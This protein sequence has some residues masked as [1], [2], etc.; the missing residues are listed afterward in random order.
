MDG[1]SF[2]LGNGIAD[3]LVVPDLAVTNQPLNISPTADVERL[4]P[5]LY[6]SCAVTRSQARRELSN[7]PSMNTES[8]NEWGLNDLFSEMESHDEKPFA[9]GVSIYGRKVEPKAPAE[10]HDMNNVPIT[11][12]ML[13]NAQQNDSKLVSFMSRAVDVEEI[14]NTP[15]CFYVKSG[16]LMPKFQPPEVPASKTWREAHQIVVPTCYKGNVL[17]LAHDHIGGHLGV[18]KTSDKILRYFYWPGIT[19]DVAEY[20]RSCHTC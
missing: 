2:L 9:S 17:Q 20:C 15:V 5:D 7:Q 4:Y 1:V 6:P 14:A 12:E 10:K 11:R 13:I 8:S 3:S 16:I 19:S 18:K